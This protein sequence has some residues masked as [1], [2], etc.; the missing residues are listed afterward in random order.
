ML[1]QMIKNSAKGI[2]KYFAGNVA[3]GSIFGVKELPDEEVTRCLHIG[4]GCMPS[5]SS[6]T[7]GNRTVVVGLSVVHA[8][9]LGRSVIKDFAG[10]ANIAKSHFQSKLIG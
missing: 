2:V 6:R 3:C 10:D 7:L 8:P 4:G 5:R 9:S 1:V